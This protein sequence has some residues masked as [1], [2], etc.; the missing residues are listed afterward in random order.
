MARRNGFTLIELV[1]VIMILGILAAVAV[2]KLLNTTATA[3]DNG[4]RQTLGV[5]RNAIEVYAATNSGKLPGADSTEATFKSD[6]KTYLRG[7]FP[8]CPIGKKDA[9]IEFVSVDANTALTPTGSKGWMYN[10]KDGRFIANTADMSGDG[11][12]SYDKF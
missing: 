3:T 8:K 11:V 10:T 2:P 6:L 4:L 1:V 5:V 12:T 7:E 9:T